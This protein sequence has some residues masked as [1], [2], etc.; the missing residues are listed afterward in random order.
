[1]DEKIKTVINVL[2]PVK[3][4]MIDKNVLY[5]VRDLDLCITEM[6]NTETGTFQTRKVLMGR[7]PMCIAGDKLCFSSR[8]GKDICVHENSHEKQY[9]EVAQAKV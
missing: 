8:G 2:E 5:T 3:D 1:M 4:M 9:K 6:K 7:A